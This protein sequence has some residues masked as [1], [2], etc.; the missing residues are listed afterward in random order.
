MAWRKEWDYSEN[1]EYVLV[2]IEAHLLQAHS[3][4]SVASFGLLWPDASFKCK[5][6]IPIKT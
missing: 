3:Y 5:L 6:N 2:K 1:Q 4:H